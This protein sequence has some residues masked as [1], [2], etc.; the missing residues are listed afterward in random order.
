MIEKDYKSNL[1]LNERISKKQKYYNSIKVNF[2]KERK[3]NYNDK[4]EEINN[5]LFDNEFAQKDLAGIQL[6][7]PSQTDFFIKLKNEGFTDSEINNFFELVGKPKD[8]YSILNIE[9]LN[10][11]I[12]SFQIPE[13]MTYIIIKTNQNKFYLDY[14]NKTSFILSSKEKYKFIE[15]FISEWKY[16]AISL[17]NKNMSREEKALLGAD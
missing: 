13:Y 15:D 5:Y 1:D 17:I 6:L 14:E 11:F 3:F 10:F 12:P 7:I 4:E 2:K 8:A 9:K 16:F